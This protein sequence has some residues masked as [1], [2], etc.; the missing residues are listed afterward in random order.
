MKNIN[1]YFVAIF[2]V[3]TIIVTSCE[4]YL[5]I[6]QQGVQSI[7]NF[8]K[9]DEQALNALADI[10]VE[11]RNNLV[12][13]HVIGP[14]LEYMSGDCFPGWANMGD[15]SGMATAMYSFTFDG[16]MRNSSFYTGPAG[17]VRRTNTVLARVEP[18]TPAKRRVLAECRVIRAWAY[19]YLAF[20]FGDVPLY[21]EEITVS[22]AARA[23]SPVAEVWDFVN[24]DFE[25]A[26]NSGDLP[27]KSSVGDKGNALRVTKEATQAL[28]GKMLLW[29]EKW[30]E[31]ANFLKTVINSG[32][33]QLL[34]DDQLHNHNGEP[35]FGYVV[36]ATT[37]LGSESLLELNSKPDQNGNSG[38]GAYGGGFA[39][40][41]DQLRHNGGNFIY[42]PEYDLAGVGNGGLGTC[43]KSLY[44]AFVEMEGPNGFRLKGSIV[45]WEEMQAIGVS[46]NGIYYCTEGYW[47]IKWRRMRSE[48]GS[49][50]WG[51]GNE[52]PF[53]PLRIMRYGEVLLN[54]AEAC[55]RSNDAASALTY[56]NIIRERAHLAPLAS[57][58]LTDIKKEKRLELYKEGSRYI[59]LL[60]WEKLNDQ[61]GITA[62]NILGEQGH[63]LPNFDGVTVNNQAF[64]LTQFG[65]KKGKHELMPIP[66]AELNANPHLTQNPGW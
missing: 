60:R 43:K 34:G 44:D 19:S 36:R 42:L 62:S 16:E 7:D 46:I 45:T 39:W 4:K 37:S 66:V 22:N 1:K 57:V 64:V 48:S 13:T 9:T 55:M 63:Y 28:Y 25:T 32:K 20:F 29:Q 10:Y 23:S 56:I 47:D 35:D 41:T 65:W 33:Y 49:W 52:S 17:M 53:S 61:D 15:N 21:E 26:I 30:S 50:T 6:S 27:S 12:G 58:T 11:W 2:L 54:A 24:K 38:P 5:D 40:R 3:F 59:D 8:Y 51:T 18:D 31:S 14:Y